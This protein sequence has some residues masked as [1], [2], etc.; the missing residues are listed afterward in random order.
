MKK[1]I[2]FL[3]TLVL[4]VTA[5]VFAVSADTAEE[6]WCDRCRKYVPASEWMEWDFTGG[7]VNQEGHFY[8]ADDYVT[9]ET[10]INIPALKFTCLDLRG[11]DW[12]T[13]GIRPLTVSGDFSIMDSVGGGQILATGENGKSGGFAFVDTAGALNLFDG[14]IQFVPK[15]GITLSSGGLFSVSAGTVNVDGATISGGVASAASDKNAFGGN[16]YLANGSRLNLVSGTIAKGMVTAGNNKQG[17]NIYATGDSTVTISGGVLEDGYAGSAGGNIFLADANLYITGGEIRDGLSPVRGG[18]IAAVSAEDTLINIS[19]GKI[20]GGVAAGSPKT[21]ADGTD[22][23]EL[24]PTCARGE[25]GGGNI[26]G[27]TPSGSLVITGGTIDGDILLD[28]MGTLTLSGAPQIG[29]GRSNG[30]HFNNSS[31]KADVSGLT[32]GAMIYVNASNVFTKPLE[33][34]AAAT[35]ALAYFRGAVR[36]TVSAATTFALQGAQGTTGYCPHCGELVTWTATI[37]AT[38]DGDHIYLSGSRYRTSN[39]VVSLNTVLDLNGYSLFQDGTRIILNSANTELKTLS[40]LDSWGGGKLEGTGTGN[41]YGGLLYMYAKSA[42]ELYSGTM[43]VSTSLKD[44]SAANI[45]STGGVIYATGA[46]K[47]TMYGGQITSGVVSATGDYGGGNIAFS[48]SSGKLIVNGGIIRSGHAAD[49]IALSGGNIYSAGIVEINGGVIMG[50]SAKYGGNIYSKT[51]LTITD[52]IV[53]NGTASSSGGN[54]YAYKLAVSGGL[55]GN[56][57]STGGGGGNIR[58]GNANATISENAVIVSGKASTYGGNLYCTEKITLSIEGGL[59]AGGTAS[60]GGNMR[61]N[62]GDCILNIS[63]GLMTMGHATDGGNAYI[64]NGTFNM[65]GGAVTAGTATKG[66]NFYFNYN[67]KATFKDDADPETPIP[68][69]SHGTAT[70]GLGGNI[71]FIAG[72]NTASASTYFMKLGNCVVRDGSATGD[73][74]NIYVNQYALFEVLPEFA[75]NTTVFFHSSLIVDD[76]YLDNKYVSCDGIYSGELLLENKSN[77]PKII[78]TQADPT[79]VIGQAALVMKDGTVQWFSSNS[80]AMEG[81][82]DQVAYIQPGAGELSLTAGTFMVDLAGGNVTINGSSDA[83][84]YCFDSGNTSYSA[85]GTATFNGPVLV[86]TKDYTSNGVRYITLA[87]SAADTYSFHCLDMRVSSASFRPGSAGIYYRCTWECDDVLKAQL[88]NFGVALSVANMPGADFAT[89]G[90][91]LYTQAS[92]NG[93]VTGQEYNSVLVNN[94]LT[95]SATNNSSRGKSPIYATPYVTLKS[96]ESIVCPGEFKHSLKSV[97]SMFDRRGYYANKAT[98]ES[99]YQKWEGAMKNWD[100]TN[101][102]KKPQ[103][104]DT[105]RILMGGNSFAYY[106]VEELYGLLMENLP[107]GVTGVEIYNFYYSGR[108]FY[109]H[110]NKWITNAPGDYHLFKTDKNGRRE[111][112]PIG[113]WTVEEVLAM[114]NWDYLGLQGVGK[115]GAGDYADADTWDAKCADLAIYAE[116]LFGYIHEMFPYTQ[117]LWHRT[118]AQE[119]GRVT[120]SGFVYTEEYNERYDPGMQYVC[121]YMTEVFDQDKPYDLVQVNSGAAWKEA[122]RLNAELIAAGGEEAGVLPYGGLCAMLAR[123][124]FGDKRPGSG[125]GQHDGDIGGGQL[126]NAYMWYMTITGDSDLTDNTFKPDYEMSDGLWNVLKQAAMTTYETY[127]NN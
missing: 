120:S 98:L 57:V 119:V 89:D 106:Y 109:T 41:A 44:S 82:N 63:G 3:M 23:G 12:I 60:T 107:E 78:T 97:L 56:G 13:E 4:L 125:D 99:F 30:L 90:D 58:M 9:Q 37:A 74:D 33:D 15:D 93:L 51:E 116:E 121:D 67:T 52:G 85:Y 45:V 21:Y 86:N 35:A 110:W 18:N 100:F 32:E 34:E 71:A 83:N 64:N 5:T 27:R 87:E 113:G 29:L 79:L 19:G 38:N 115:S 118:W 7:D 31:I 94:I 10:T 20:T 123:N 77:L 22:D 24:N 62:S 11:N 55:I 114:E 17:G 65:T 108:S 66:G 69:V 59:I 28:Y 53:W 80:A 105:L 112:T 6:V 91:T 117:L 47:I 42:L 49:S 111:L 95:E 75:Q 101:I 102:G 2:I 36:T 73:G 92:A 127:Y 48:S 46:A 88:E 50:G 122:R 124:T 72:G 16:F 68:V 14:N 54:L 8:L 126:L 1:S 96:G 81:Y 40:V 61:Q 103:D 25:Y 70:G 104:D 39:L 76:I 26:Y 43:R 84:V